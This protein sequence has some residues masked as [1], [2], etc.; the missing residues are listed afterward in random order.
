MHEKVSKRD[1]HAFALVLLDFLFDVQTGILSIPKEKCE[2]IQALLGSVLRRVRARQLV[3]LR[4]VSS[5]AGK[6]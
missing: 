2:E 1:G 3:S 4:E 6:L 5:L